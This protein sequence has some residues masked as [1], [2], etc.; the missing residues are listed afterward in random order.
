LLYLWR[1]DMEASHNQWISVLGLAKD[2]RAA[3][4]F[5]MGAPDLGLM[6]YDML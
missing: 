3:T 2:N 4:V 5:D 1:H 6:P